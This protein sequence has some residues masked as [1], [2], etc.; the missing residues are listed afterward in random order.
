[1]IEIWAKKL[2][3]GNVITLRQHTEDLLNNLEKFYEKLPKK[4][5]GIKKDDLFKLLKYASF[6]HDLGKVSPK[7]QEN[8]G[9]K[10]FHLDS[11]DF[12]NIRHNIF[13]LFFINK[14]KVR[15]ICQN[16]ESLYGVF[17]S[18]IALH[19][20]RKDEE[21]Y[22]LHINNDLKKV[23]EKLF[24]NGNREVLANI[25]KEH[26]KGFKI[27]DQKAEDLISF[28]EHLAQHIKEG[29]NL[30]SAGIIPP[31]TLYFFPER[32]KAELEQ[33]IDLKLW[34]FLSGFLMRIDHFASFCE[35][36]NLDFEIEKEIPKY[37]LTNN[38]SQKFGENFWQKEYLKLK[39]QNIILIAPTGI[40]KTELAFLWAEDEKFFYTLPL[41]VAT[42]QIFDRACNY[43]NKNKSEDEDPFINGNVGLLHSDA[44][45]YI[46]EKWETSKSTEEE[47][48][49]PKIIEISKHFSLPVNI[50]T[51]DQIFPSAL[52]YPG[53][54]KIYATLGYS[55]LIIDEVQAYDPRACAIIVKMIKDIVFLGG[56]FLL[57]TATLPGFV[58]EEFKEELENKKIKYIDLYKGKIKNGEEEKETIK[59]KED[60]T[61]HK[62]ELK[63]EDIEKD[64]K[65]IVNKAKQGKRVLVVLNTV[66]KAKEVYK[67]I[68]NNG[69]NGFLEILHSR[70]TLNKRKEKER[71]LEEE[72]KNPKPEDEKS[73]KILVATQVVEVSL[74][75]DAD[76][77]FTEIA[78]I[79]SLIQR[80][81]RVMRRVNL[82]NGKIK[83]SDE[84]FKYENFYKNE[85]NIFIYCVKEENK[86]RES[87][88]GRV[89]ENGL[90]QKAYEILKDKLKDKKEIN[91]S[92][93]QNLVIEFYEKVKNDKNSE[94]LKKFYETLRI[95]NAGYV[96]KNKDEAHKI[97]RE[98]YT[99]PIVDNDKVEEIVE[100][101]NKATNI[102]W[103]WFKKEI[104]AEYVINENMWKY[105]EYELEKL[106][107]K[108][109]GKI[110]LNENIK[111]I[112]ENYS[113]GIYVSKISEKI[114]I[115]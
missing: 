87:G 65:E 88:G 75:I 42:N 43:F 61:R 76:Y 6:F 29:G 64:I 55:K 73:P 48:E 90:V 17:L 84:E 49:I 35:K 18:S 53:Y 78:P 115:L 85:A 68:E 97:F 74:D 93:K 25:L 59:I 9:N 107:D 112:L 4:I 40:G 86:I 67:K 105:K 77:L 20:W 95:L 13:S 5:G 51:G 72:F 41:R 45:L 83:R 12:P 63:E 82:M 62:I 96:S 14:D 79:D 91:E 106:W 114:R 24:E 36:E 108:I 33:K 3:D 80:M 11:K 44:D 100:K 39:D 111:K 69:F 56:K 66:E 99:I 38:F 30:I 21:E 15:E 94:Y 1:M 27:D 54:E 28:D 26:F 103:L 19:H 57:M 110:T 81:G 32:L 46:V 89:Y 92:E 34:I 37:N 70:F 10:D 101:I 2:K 60:I 50:S 98:I 109:K 113:S 8:I 102:T 31:Y 47:G 23:C 58:E 71:K 52:K 7:F 104:I 22:L 16:D